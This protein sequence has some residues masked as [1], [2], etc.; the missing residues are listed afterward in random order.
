MGKW[1]KAIL[2]FIAGWVGERREK[3]G[4]VGAYAVAVGILIV[5]LNIWEHADFLA[6]KREGFQIV[7]G[8]V[9]DVLLSP[10]F[11]YTLFFVGGVGLIGLHF[12]DKKQRG[13]SSTTP[14]NDLWPDEQRLAVLQKRAKEG[15]AF[16]AQALATA[17]PAQLSGPLYDWHQELK[18]DF[19]RM[20][21]P[22][23]THLVSQS[24]VKWDSIQS[25]R[26]YLEVQISQLNLLWKQLPKGEGR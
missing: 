12:Y 17:Q 19:A 13:F 5:G 9:L 18:D 8:A 14:S 15:E 6:G 23:A 2:K 25:L 10:A 21:K 16:L 20:P 22:W 4:E 24:E 26:K 3:Y 11:G 7:L 1:R